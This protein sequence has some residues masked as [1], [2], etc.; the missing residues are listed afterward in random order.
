MRTIIIC[1]L[2]GATCSSFANDLECNGCV[3]TGDIRSQA[4]TTQKIAQGA[5]TE[6][7]LAPDIQRKLNGL[8]VTDGVGR[9]LPVKLSAVIGDS[10][11]GYLR[12]ESADV[13]PITVFSPGNGEPHQISG[14]SLGYPG[15]TR[16]VSF[17]GA[18]CTGQPYVANS[19]AGGNAVGDWLIPY[20]LVADPVAPNR[21]RL[22]YR[23]GEE[24][25]AIPIALSYIS[26]GVGCVDVVMNIASGPLD[27][28]VGDGVLDGYLRDVPVPASG[29]SNGPV[30]GPPVAYFAITFVGAIKWVPPLIIS[31][32][33]S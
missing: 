25:D 2:F 24:L 10:A 21:S 12:L 29:S 32:V 19:Y 15:L 8:V 20:G 14:E 31:E 18:G 3:H 11:R 26:D 33:G 4:I 27:G 9:V 30:V 5:V 16:G 1:V 6:G 7:K 17:T 28:Y 23:V 22:I 13:V